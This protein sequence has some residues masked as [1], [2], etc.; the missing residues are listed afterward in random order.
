METLISASLLAADFLALG[1]DI[2]RAESA[3]ADWLHYDVMDG[4]FVPSVSFGEPVLKCIQTAAAAPVDVHLMVVHPENYIKRYAELGARGITFHLEA[5]DNPRAVISLIHECGCRAGISIKPDT[6]AELLF[7]YIDVVDLMLVMTVEPGFGGQKFM[8][9]TIGKISEL[10]EKA[11]LMGREVH[12][13]VDGGI[14]ADTAPLARNAGADVLVSGSY[15]FG[16]D[17][18]REHVE[19]LKG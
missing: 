15:L 13:Q 10:R 7:P 5:A 19:R 2:K 3:G 16:S 17:D 9:Q 18:M 1:A 4:I 11:D 8:P 14:N 12:I 6:P